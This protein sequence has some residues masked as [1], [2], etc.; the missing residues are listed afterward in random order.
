MNLANYI[1]DE[2]LILIPVLMIIGKIVKNTPK[3]KNWLIPYILLVLGVVLAGLMMGFS[4]NSFI[5]GVL[6]AG[7]A[8]F[9]HQIVK[10]TIEKKE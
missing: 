8:V 6:V 2:A 4:V 1:M 5:Q 9:G 7:T 3:I 10:Q